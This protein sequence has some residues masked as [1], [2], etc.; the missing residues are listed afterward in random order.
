MKIHYIMH[1]DFE[2]IG[3]IEDWA[4]GQNH[5]L[6]GSKP[7]KGDKLPHVS[8]FDFLVIM[9]GP[10]SP[11][12]MDKAPYLRDEIALIKEAVKA[13]KK[14]LG[15]CLGAQLIGEALGGNTSQSPS[16]EVGVFPVTLTLKGQQDP[17]FK[18]FPPSFEVIHWHNDMPGATQ[19]SELLAQSVGCPQQA[20]RYKHNVY[21]LQFHMEITNESIQELIAHCPDDLQPGSF[22]QSAEELSRQDLTPIND[23]MKLILNRLVAL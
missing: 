19:D 22:V 2:P 1:A 8:D 23:N 13:D 16:K 14:V 21:G 7:F 18:G 4:Y 3:C 9:G 20:Y 11:L 10:Q 5:I 17:L 15:F 6:K 12:A